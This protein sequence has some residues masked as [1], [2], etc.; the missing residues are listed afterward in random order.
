MED[1]GIC[2]GGVTGVCWCRESLCI[3]KNSGSGVETVVFTGAAT[4]GGGGGDGSSNS[5]Q[6]ST[7]APALRISFGILSLLPNSTVTLA[8]F[9]CFVDVVIQLVHTHEAHK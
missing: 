9:L 6:N 5:L 7:K 8:F 3:D 4:S 2:A 1:R